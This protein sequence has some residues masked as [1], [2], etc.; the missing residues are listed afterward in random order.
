MGNP[1]A[2]EYEGLSILLIPRIA[3]VIMA[4]PFP[5]VIAVVGFIVSVEEFGPVNKKGPREAALGFILL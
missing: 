1:S 4:L 3:Q 2:G 5:V